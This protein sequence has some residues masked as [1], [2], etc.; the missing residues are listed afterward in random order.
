MDAIRAML[1]RLRADRRGATAIEYGLLA[2]LIALGMLAGLSALG[3]GS[4][5]LWGKVSTRVSDAMTK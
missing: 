5:G 2:A 3:D 1:R 4:T